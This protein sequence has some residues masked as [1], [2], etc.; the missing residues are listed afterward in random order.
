MERW[1]RGR[2][3]HPSSTGRARVGDDGRGQPGFAKGRS[4]TGGGQNVAERM[5]EANGVELCTEAFGDPADPPILLDHGHR[6]IDALVG[7]GLLSHAG[8]RRAVRDPLRPPRHRPIGDLR[9]G[10]PRVQRRRPGRRCRRCA[11]RI[12]YP[13][14]AHGRRLGRRG[15]RAA[16]RTDFPDRVLSLVLISTSPATPGDRGL[17]SAD[18]GVRALRGDRRSRL[19]GRGVGGRVPGR[20]LP[21]AHGGRRP[22]DE[23]ASRELIRRDVARARNIAASAEPRPRR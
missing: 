13:G 2:G 16:A 11:R 21:C 20:L 1:R 7:G 6:R 15:L 23:A 5:I 9:A 3:R 12:R 8:R 14:R 17:P 10:A 18:G 4:P 19:V 22:F